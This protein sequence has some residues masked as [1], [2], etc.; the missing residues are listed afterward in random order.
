DRLHAMASGRE[1]PARAHGAI[2]FADISGFTPLTEAFERRLGARRGGEEL[3]QHLNAIYSAL[4]SEVHRFRGSVIGFSGDAMTCFFDL[5]DGVSAA[6]C[7]LSMLQ[8]TKRFEE[9]TSSTHARPGDIASLALKVAVTSG[10]VRRLRV[11]A[12]EHQLLDVLAGDALD[13]AAEAESLAAPGELMVGREV[14]V[15]LGSRAETDRRVGSFA[16]VHSTVLPQGPRP[17]P[18][19]A[20]FALDEE[21]LRPWLIAPV[22]ERLRSGHGDFLAELR[23]ATALFVRF[24]GLDFEA[25][26]DASG[27][28]DAYVRWVQDIVARYEGSVLQLTTGDKGSYLYAAFGVPLAHEDAALRALSAALLLRA[29]PPRLDFV[30]TTQIGISRGLMRSGAYGSEERR[31]YGA[32]GDETNVAARLM[33]KAAQ[34]QILVSERIAKDHAAADYRFEPL[35]TVTL[36]GKEAMPVFALAGRAFRRASAR[37]RSARRS[38]EAT[39]P[40]FDAVVGRA[41]ERAFLH[42]AVDAFH[43]TRESAVVVI[44]ADAGLGKSRLVSDVLAYASTKRPPLRRLVAIAGGIERDTSYFAWRSVFAELLRIDPLGTPE[45]IAAHVLAALPQALVPF[46]PLL[47]SVLE[48]DLPETKESS[49]LPPHMRAARIA[50]FLVRVFRALAGD[51][52]ILLI[53]EDAHWLDSASWALLD[54]LRA[55]TPRLLLVLTTRPLASAPQ[56]YAN[57]C[58]APGARRLSLDAMSSEEAAA[59]AAQVLGVRE[60]PDAV[61]ALVC[62]KAEG[63]PFF[64][65]QLALALRDLGLIRV[66]D[67]ALTVEKA[68]DGVG[69]PDTIEGVV[70]SR[71]DRL[72]PAQQLTLT[73]ASVVGRAVRRSTLEEV[74]PIERERD[75]LPEI[76]D[77]LTRLDLMVC[78]SP[79]PDP[80]YVFRH[81]VTRDVSYDLMLFEQRRALHETIADWYER[82]HAGDLRPFFAVLAH[83]RE[84]ALWSPARRR[85][86][87]VMPRGRSRSSRH[88]PRHTNGAGSSSTRGACSA[89]PLRWSRIRSGATCS[90]SSSA[91]ESCA[92]SSAR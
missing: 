36:K 12:P 63:N 46:S 64:T 69:F 84:S 28:L 40:S 29:P 75:L 85:K 73:V 47:E 9:G 5:D 6:S 71:I 27:K 19:L 2:L 65:E 1:L 78:E 74:F 4:V 79:E 33:M 26:D 56:P 62:E 38:V 35:G 30:T 42:D 43:R 52:P 17:W 23:Q 3:T 91:R 51:G 15:A 83:H 39:R 53:V 76:L 16:A 55:E 77:E 82:A 92:W 70:T 66:D 87:F 67:G 41:A 18:E 37:M 44:E 89:L 13:R 50:P 60:I 20:A 45:S 80:G 8:A 48:I 10:P 7:G 21:S 49:A 22:Y 57:L 59:L 24:G 58:R 31:T 88:C 72:A 68:L 14:A 32:L 61:R 90:A 54:L 34:E 86:P 25:D 11:G 81:A